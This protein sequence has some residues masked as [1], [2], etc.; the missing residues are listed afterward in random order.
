MTKKRHPYYAAALANILRGVSAFTHVLVEGPLQAGGWV[1]FNTRDQPLKCV[2]CSDQ[3]CVT[4]VGLLGVISSS[5]PK[6][7]FL[8]VRCVQ[9]VG[10]D[11]WWCAFV[12]TNIELVWQSLRLRSCHLFAKGICQNPTTS[13]SFKGPI[14]K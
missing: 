6:N 11:S 5:K 12:R 8:V 10:G 13:D 4:L 9:S 14:Y 3:S 1:N 7:D 2:R